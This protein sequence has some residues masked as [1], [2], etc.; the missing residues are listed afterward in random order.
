M[1]DFLL[2]LGFSWTISKALPYVI[3]LVVG[4]VLFFL[5]R[6]KVKSRLGKV[7]LSLVIIVPV[8]VYF[9]I[10]PIYEGDFS[11]DYRTVSALDSLDFSS[12]ELTVLAIAHC[13]YCAGSIEKLNKMI[14]RTEAERIN[15]VVITDQDDVL[16]NYEELACDEISFTT[17]PS[18]EKYESIS[19]GRFPTFVYSD[20]KELSIWHNDGFGV[21]AIDWVEEQLER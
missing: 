14:E 19:T 20:G 6:K 2:S 18:F 5:F 11:N 8:G 15:F 16:I 10:S 21:R 4:L 3:F 13:P 1:N 12:D 7:L 9:A 17:V